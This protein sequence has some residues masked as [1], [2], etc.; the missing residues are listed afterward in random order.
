M[1]LD[2]ATLFVTL[3]LVAAM[4]AMF[5]W[6]LS[7]GHRSIPGIRS[8]TLS[9]T[10][11]FVGFTLISVRAVLPPFLSFIVANAL[12]CIGYTLILHGIGKFFK[13]NISD[14][15]LFLAAFFYIVE[16]S[17]FFL[18][19]NSFSARLFSYLFYY[20]SI[21]LVA[22]WIVLSEF[23]Q[24]RLSSH[25]AAA[26]FIGFLSVSFFTLAAASLSQA[27]VAQIFSPSTINAGVV[28]GQITFVVGWTFAFT[29]LVSERLNA[30]KLRAES[31]SRE[32]S[33]ALANMSHELR[34]PLNAII[35]F[36]DVI[37][38]QALGANHP[39]YA[40][41]VTDI[42]ASGRHL[43]LLIEDILDIS[44]IEAGRLELNERWFP[45]P[46][47][48][49]TM[50]HM[51]MLKAAGKEIALEVDTDPAFPQMRGDELRVRQILLNLAT[52]AIKFTPQGGRVRLL[53]RL[54]PDGTGL[55]VVA[56]NGI[57]MDEAGIRRARTK[58]CQVDDIR[59]RQQ[60]G[61][62]LGLPLAVALTEAHGGTLQIDSVPG[63]GTTI[64]VSF[65]AD[66]CRPPDDGPEPG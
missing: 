41:Y 48:V 14:L 22:L 17:Y 5:V 30:D 59:V 25:L 49:E 1:N 21:M 56:D 10:L 9:N 58:Y 11:L 44:K 2:I 45:V 64:T 39:R 37:D 26:L 8:I 51:V 52:N 12:I 31:S 38:K 15:V 65:P 32:K 60:E 66:R 40:E 19:E 34:T 16:F 6:F 62:G 7:I 55:L 50:R 24:V 43:L 28:L 42:L 46:A 53:T 23:R 36:A 4:A 54:A 47:M 29:L 63:Q 13:K 61:I 20:A 3:D 35:G 57:G 27:N 18:V 33:D